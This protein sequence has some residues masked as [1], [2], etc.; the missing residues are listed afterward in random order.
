MTTHESR[1]LQLE[2]AAN[3]RDLGGLPAS[4]EGFVRRGRIFR[5][6]VLFRL[7]ESDTIALRQLGLRTVIDLRSRGEVSHYPEGPLKI[8][9]LQHFNVPVETDTY[10][11]TESMVEDYLLLLRNAG[12]GFR[13]IF[14]HLAN[15][16]Y[17]LVINCFAGKDRTGLTSVLILGALGVPNDEIVADYALSEQHMLRLMQIHGRT[18]DAMVESDALP[19]WLAATSATM[20]ATLHA[21]SEE[22]GS[23]GG[24]L[25]SIGIPAEELRKI[26]DALVESVSEHQ[27]E[28]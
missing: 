23:V 18:D 14:G 12:A 27:D 28:P 10:S 4:D 7:T 1:I 26:R 19:T 9:G 16:H 25:E 8:A 6:D 3:F 21:I 17:P 15:D 2:G 22:W 13:V 5:S 24:Y 11:E 20:E